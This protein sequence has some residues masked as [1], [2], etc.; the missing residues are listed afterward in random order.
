[1]VAELSRDK[2]MLELLDLQRLVGPAAAVP[3][4][5]AAKRRLADAQLLADLAD[6][7]AAG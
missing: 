4:S 7:H 5:A 2:Q 1:L 6:G 3:L